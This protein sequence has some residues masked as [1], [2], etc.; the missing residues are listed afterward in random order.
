[1][2]WHVRQ[3]MEVLRGVC[4]DVGGELYD[5]PSLNTSDQV[6]SNSPGWH[7]TLS[8]REVNVVLYDVPGARDHFSIIMNAW[9][10]ITL[11]LRREERFDWLKKSMGKL[12][13]VQVGNADFDRDFLIGGRPEGDVKQFL[14]RREVQDWVKTL[15][16]FHHL[17]GD[18]G[19]FRATFPLT[20]KTRYEPED[21]RVRVVSML[22]LAE[23]V[24]KVGLEAPRM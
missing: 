23:A 15:G 1:M 11:S 24:E 9:P 13:D 7:A 2:D 22:R 20:P 12:Q 16:D 8:G 4:K 10:R 17:A 19:F 18:Q 5:S 21:L 14:A 6:E 3:M